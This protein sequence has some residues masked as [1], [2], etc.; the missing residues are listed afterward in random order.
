MHKYE[1][2]SKSYKF[3]Q[4]FR[5]VTQ[6]HLCMEFTNTKIKTEI[7]ITFSGFI[8]SGS[9]LAKKKSS[10]MALLSGWGLG[11]SSMTLVSYGFSNKNLKNLAALKLTIFFPLSNDDRDLFIEFNDKILSLYYQ[12]SP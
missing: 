4:D 9:V 10:T 3:Q 8:R 1:I 6:S 5:C 12:K 11:T 7:W 2:C